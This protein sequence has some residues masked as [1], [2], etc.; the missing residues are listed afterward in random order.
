MG[1]CLLG[2]LLDSS[3]YTHIQVVTDPEDLL[4]EFV[5]HVLHLLSRPHGVFALPQQRRWRRSLNLLPRKVLTRGQIGDEGA[6]LEFE[7]GERNLRLTASTLS[8]CWFI[9]GDPTGDV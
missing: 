6:W 5:R 9:Q 4:P 7:R 2:L 8:I 1:L 3:W